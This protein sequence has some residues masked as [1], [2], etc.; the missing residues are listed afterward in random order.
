[1]PM[2]QLGAQRHLAVE[3]VPMQQSHDGQVQCARSSGRMRRG[4][5]ASLLLLLQPLPAR[6]QLARLS[7]TS[8]VLLLSC[9]RVVGAL[10]LQ[11]QAV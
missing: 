10:L 1:M 9:L 11:R 8:T 4:P 7:Q 5:T 3:N 2:S 6:G